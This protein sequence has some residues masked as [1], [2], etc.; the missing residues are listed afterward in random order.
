MSKQ[1]LL[2]KIELLRQAAEG[3]DDPDKT[4]MLSDISILIIKLESFTLSEITQ[5]MN[6]MSLPEISDMDT[7]IQ[8]ANNAINSHGNRVLAFNNAFSFIKRAFG[9]VI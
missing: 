6:S 9:I 3:L 4:F 8:V 7:E 1:E 2:N 5:K